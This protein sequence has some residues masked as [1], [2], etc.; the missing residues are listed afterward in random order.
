MRD[1]R[2]LAYDLLAYIEA[3]TEQAP[4]WAM[5]EY[6]EGYQRALN[7]IEEQIR[8]VINSLS[9]KLDNTN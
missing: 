4:L 3:N 9:Q 7:D 8:T 2:D 1:E 5:G 6:L